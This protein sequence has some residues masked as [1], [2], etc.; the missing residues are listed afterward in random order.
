MRSSL[1]MSLLTLLPVWSACWLSAPRGEVIHLASGDSVRVLTTGPAIVPNE[2]PGLQIEYNPY[3]SLDDTVALKREALALWSALR[4][5]ID[6]MNPPFV[7]LRATTRTP[8]VIGYQSVRNYGF[9]I[10]RR[11]DGKWYFLNAKEPIRA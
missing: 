6:S 8:Q 10:E 3:L 1:P 11:A 9:V 7:V 4:P 2:R 5:R